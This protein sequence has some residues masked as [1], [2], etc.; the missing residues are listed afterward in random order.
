[1]NQQ[2]IGR[3]PRSNPVT[4]T[5][6]FSPIR[7]LFTGLPES[8]AQGLQAGPVQ[9]QREGRALRGLRGERP[10]QD[11]DALPARRLRDL[12]RLPR[13]PVQPGHPRG[14]LQGQEHRRGPRHDRPAGP[15]LL[16]EH[17]GDPLEAPAPATTS[18]LGYIRLGQSATTLS[19]GEAQRIKLSREL[20]KRTN[21]QT[22]STSSTSRRSACTSPTSRSSSTS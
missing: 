12:R 3:T 10:D 17:P 18:G 20:G 7:D 11:R 15:R 22:P 6:I 16:R 8:R 1:M 21:R 5:G 19:G 4:Y 9:L 14:P 13:Q 2:P